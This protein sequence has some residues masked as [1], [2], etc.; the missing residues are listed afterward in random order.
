ME[1]TLEIEA[2][3]LLTAL[4]RVAFTPAEAVCAIVDNAIE[5]DAKNIHILTAAGRSASFSR[6]YIIIDDGKGMDEAGIQAAL[7][8]G[9][10]DAHY[11]PHSL[12]K[13]GLGL[14]SAAFSQGD[15]LEVISS[16][17]GGVPF[18]KYR[19]SLPSI[20]DSYF[21]TRLS[22]SEQDKELLD[23]HLPEGHGTLVRIGAVRREGHPA[24]KETQSQLLYRVGVI[25]YYFLLEGN[26]TIRLEGKPI[27]AVDVLFT[28]EANKNGNLDDS[29]W[30]G[31]ETRWLRRQTE[32]P[33]DADTGVTCLLEATQLPHPPTFAN[34]ERGG[35]KA[36]RDKYLITAKNYGYYVYRNKRLIAWADSLDGMIG[37]DQ[38][39]WSF[40]GRI[41]I[42]DSADNVFNID[43]KKTSMKLSEEA[44][45]TIFDLNKDYKRNSIKAWNRAKMLKKEADNEDPNRQSNDIISLLNTPSSLPGQPAL[46][47]TKEAEVDQ[48]IAA[49]M[50]ANIQHQVEQA[51]AITASV[52]GPA[53]DNEPPKTE[54]EQFEETLKGEDNPYLTKIFRVPSLPDNQLWE[55]YFDAEH[56]HCVRIN[57]YHRF[58][59]LLFVE[60]AANTDMQVMFE[61]F[62][63][64]LAVAEV[65]FRRMFHETFPQLKLNDEKVEQL[66]SEFRKYAAGNL[67][68]M[69][70]KIDG[71]LPHN[72]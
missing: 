34:D 47:P 65:Q 22:V 63:H 20:T 32:V 61:L 14:K 7:T 29:T 37:Y 56:E 6:D 69:C 17:G 1:A 4:R 12:S 5:A 55:P 45:D 48:E 42:D 59:K 35:D 46:S 53:A 43:V 25:Y 11:E 40:R 39:L 54:E 41:L 16:P 8:L 71:Q 33:L 3:K 18:V 70:G 68:Y 23:Q 58:A 57:R 10:S 15:D 67:A 64:Q 50:K 36:I 2:G 66:T 26:L 52:K 24:V 60:N 13:F 62:L 44:W 49:R 31:R 28:D 38:D 30:N 51:A 9:A 27:K 72:E 21:A 19:V